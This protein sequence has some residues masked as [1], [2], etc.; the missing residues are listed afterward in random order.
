MKPIAAFPGTKQHQALLNSIVA[1]YQNDPRVLSVIVFGSLGR[2]SWDEYSDLDLDVIVADDVKIDISNELK[3]LCKSFA[4]LSERAAIILPNGD[5]GD[6][7]LESLMQLSIRYHPLSQTSP[8]IVDSMLVLAGSLDHTEITAA[9]NKN[10]LGD[11]KP[12]SQLLDRCVRYAVVANVEFH[13]RHFWAVN[14]V[15]HRIRTLIMDI[16]ACTHNGYRGYQ[17]FDINA[18]ERFQQRLGAALPTFDGHSLQESFKK[19]LDIIESDLSYLSGGQ[20]DLTTAQ[21]IVLDR[22]RQQ[23]DST[24]GRAR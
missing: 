13:R 16:Y 12:I 17:F 19:T 2:G 6:I 7:I 15:L 24:A 18:E 9:G 14:D 10:R 3:R 21:K 1:F 11:A 4:G 5:E 20:L 8:N 22:V 23:I